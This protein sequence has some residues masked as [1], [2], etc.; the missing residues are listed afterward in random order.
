MRLW[1]SAFEWSIGRKKFSGRKKVLEKSAETLEARYTR[2]LSN[3]LIKG[4]YGFRQNE[5]NSRQYQG[6]AVILIILFNK[7]FIF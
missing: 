5:A 3:Y 4:K 2:R 7:F 6:I 1:F